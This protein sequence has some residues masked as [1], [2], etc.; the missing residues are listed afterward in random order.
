MKTYALLQETSDE[1]LAAEEQ[2][3]YEKILELR[4]NDTAYGVPLALNANGQNSIGLFKRS[5][6]LTEASGMVDELKFYCSTRFYA[7]IPELDVAYDIPAD[8]GDCQLFIL[9]DAGT[10]LTLVQY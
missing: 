6:Y 1:P 3:M 5:L 9:G 10:E 2:Q 8:W 4:E 7:L